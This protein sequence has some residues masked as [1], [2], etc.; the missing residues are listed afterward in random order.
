[1]IKFI[2]FPYLFEGRVFSV[3]LKKKI[4]DSLTWKARNWQNLDWQLYHFFNRT[5]WEKIKVF[6]IDRMKEEVE[7]LKKR[8]E[9]LNK[10]C[11]KETVPEKEIEIQYRDWS[12]EGVTLLGL[13]LYENASSQW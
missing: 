10:E 2:F 7:N 8:N 13:K 5:L 9:E 4:D 1:M 11:I 6:G 12:P 3:F